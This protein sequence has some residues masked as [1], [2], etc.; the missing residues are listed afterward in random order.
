MLPLQWLQP[1]L[2]YLPAKPEHHSQKTGDKILTVFDELQR[3]TWDTLYGSPP[4]HPSSKSASPSKKM[5]IGHFQDKSPKGSVDAPIQHL[6]DLINRHF[7]ICTLSSC[8][9]RISLFDPN[10]RQ[11]QSKVDIETDAVV[12][13]REDEGGTVSPFTDASGKGRG[14][15]VVVSHDHLD[16]E[17]L[18][19]AI[20]GSTDRQPTIGDVG[21]LPWSLKFEPMLLH[22]AAGSLETGQA[23][24][25]LALECG[26]RESGLVVTPKRVT[27]AIRS[28]SLAL[29][30]PL[31]PPSTAAE[32]G[33]D[34][35]NSCLCPTPEF[36]RAIG[37]QCNQRLT[38][39][40]N[41][42]ERLYQAL[43]QKWF[44]LCLKPR[45]R[46]ASS[47]PL[48]PLRLWNAATAVG[49]CTAPE[50]DAAPAPSDNSSRYIYTFGGYGKG[51]E[52][53]STSSRRTSLI[54]Q[55][56]IA[57]KLPHN[58]A[59]PGSPIMWKE[60][61]IPSS[62]T[63]HA[64]WESLSN[65]TPLEALPVACQ[66]MAAATLR[67]WIVLWGGRASP[68]QPLD[69]STIHLFHPP[70]NQL[71]SVQ[72]R[73][74]N[75]LPAP[76]W[77]HS[78]MTLSNNRLVLVGGGICAEPDANA[79]NPLVP[80][81]VMDDL[82]IL[83]YLA[84][85]GFVWEKLDNVKLA[86]GRTHAAATVCQ[87]SRNGNYSSQ[88][89]DTLIVAG[90]LLPTITQA[91]PLL[92]FSESSSSVSPAGTETIFWSCHVGASKMN[93]QDDGTIRVETPAWQS[94]PLV[95]KVPTALMA[96][97]SRFFGASMS[98][99]FG[100]QMVAVT[101]G[102]S[103]TPG[104]QTKGDAHV[105][106]SFQLCVVQSR[107]RSDPLVTFALVPIS[108][109]DTPSSNG[110][111]SVGSRHLD[112]GSL[113]HHASV[114]LSDTELVL[115]GGGVASFSFG[116]SFASSYHL[117]VV[118]QD[119]D[120][121]D[122]DSND[123]KKKKKKKKKTLVTDTKMDS[124][125]SQ[126]ESAAGHA[127][128]TAAVAPNPVWAKVVYVEPKDAKRVKTE[129]QSR[130]WLDKGVRMIPVERILDVSTTMQGSQ[131]IED[132]PSPTNSSLP[133]RKV[134]AI[135]IVKESW[136]DMTST[137]SSSSVPSQSWLSC[138]LGTGEEQDMPLSTARFAD[139]KHH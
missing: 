92:F 61:R 127:A 43:E 9:G 116:E 11:M 71:A 65:I 98:S 51:P 4:P 41:H 85:D 87:Q 44:R 62:T 76:R 123:G 15:W 137:V 69:A 26:F 36:V 91:N 56:R 95:S 96:N 89:W 88:C 126:D 1:C 66:G 64:C 94:P 81:P 35:D 121:S 72:V 86:G 59:A 135:P 60:I 29:N 119:D 75:H 83:H 48:P 73:Q 118:L 99:L 49:C 101:G 7:A 30:M 8:S 130:G 6:V 131:V 107:S 138:V 58:A 117:Q 114:A 125:T 105:S 38:Q 23:L 42:M 20:F 79:A 52:S 10:E 50:K 77:G 14:T 16:P 103:L 132:S 106:E 18:V 136:A 133:L 32:N 34:A 25:Q 139:R 28:H 113:V 27:V 129:L 84:Q 2:P 104:E 40:W 53:T 39:N 54:Y 55:L 37:D 111:S 68:F 12:E 112:F 24:L 124:T 80:T 128:T 120:E 82:Y 5:S 19:Q 78:L 63:S 70:T 110:E 134:I 46:L 57:R 102:V 122:E 13:E 67:E 47:L 97:T 17:T 109:W 100:G 21:I 90:G 22:I 108:S 31:V 115:V 33:S 45:V 3:K 74:D 93:R